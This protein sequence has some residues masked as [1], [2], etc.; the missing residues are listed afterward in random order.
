[1]DSSVS[2]AID[3]VS[4]ETCTKQTFRTKEKTVERLL[5]N[6]L[7]KLLVVFEVWRKIICITFQLWKIRNNF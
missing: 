5:L 7:G 6:K 3:R 4:Q 2:Y 1:M